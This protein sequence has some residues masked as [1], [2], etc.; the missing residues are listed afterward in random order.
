MTDTTK[1][2]L[3]LLKERADDMGIPYSPNIGVDK[4]REK[5]NAKLAPAVEEVKTSPE[6]SKN[7]RHQALRLEATKLIRVIVTC[8]NPSKKE[9]V[10]EYVKAGNSIV[11][12]VTRF[13][14]F[15]TETHLE[16]I[17]VKHL[18]TREYSVV[19]HVKDKEGKVH[20]Q[21]KM[22]KEFQIQRLPQLTKEELANLAA[23]QSK[24][25]SS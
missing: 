4:L 13:V 10:G 20:P 6:Q 2:E 14:P 16:E 23:E 21:R 7:A 12:T 25:K 5:V 9:V 22:R 18:E 11:P 24:R 15:E 3:E 19:I 1:S 17:G 8:L